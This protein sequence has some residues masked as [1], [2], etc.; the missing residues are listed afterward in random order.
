MGCTDGSDGQNCAIKAPAPIVLRDRHRRLCKACTKAPLASLLKPALPPSTPLHLDIT[1]RL[2][3][4]CRSEGVWLCQPCGR[5]IRSD[6]YDYRRWVDDTYML[7][8]SCPNGLSANPVTVA[9]GSGATSTAKSSVAWAPE[10]ATATAASSVA[11]P[12]SAVRRTTR[13]RRRTATPK[14]HARQR[15]SCWAPRRRPTP[16]RSRWSPTRGASRPAPTASALSA[17]SRPA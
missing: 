2:I 12:A 15:G 7:S 14:T 13:S 9:F 17:A 1:Q 6:D 4:I 8:C 10:S 11:A 16:A 3:C 5:S